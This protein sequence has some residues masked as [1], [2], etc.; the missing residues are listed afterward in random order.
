MGSL[1]ILSLAVLL[2]ICEC[3]KS[4]LIIPPKIPT[5]LSGPPGVRQNHFFGQPKCLQGYAQCRFLI[6]ER[7]PFVAGWNC[8][9]LILSG[10]WGLSTFKY[11]HYIDFAGFPFCREKWW[12]MC[13]RLAWGLSLFEVAILLTCALMPGSPFC[14]GQW[15]WQSQT[16]TKKKGLGTL[17]L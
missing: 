14:R 2:S 6:L 15:L 13:F 8:R 16:C 17:I 12:N 5:P 4:S 1:V 9:F 10:F 11:T 7:G 3:Y